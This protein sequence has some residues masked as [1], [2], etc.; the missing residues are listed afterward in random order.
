M[1]T[2]DIC[3]RD[4][5]FCAPDASVLEAAKLMREHHVGSLIVA[6]E[7]A[8]VGIVTDRDL[9]IEV[10]AEDVLPSTLRVSDVMKREL[11]SA[12]ESEDVFSVLELMQHHGIRRMPVVDQYGI[13]AGIITLDDLLRVLAKEVG[14]M[15]RLITRERSREVERRQARQ[16]SAALAEF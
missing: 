15:V 7:H 5:V 12:G 9:A 1:R 14:I 6:E 2:A 13:V 10:V 8:P 11:I 16:P 4:V 3:K